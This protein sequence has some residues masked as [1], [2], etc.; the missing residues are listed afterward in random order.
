[1]SFPSDLSP[2]ACPQRPLQLVLVGTSLESESDQVV[3]AGLAVARA[4]RARV[5]LV[6]GAEIQPPLVGFEPGPN[7]A[8][9]RE[10]L[11]AREEKLRQ[12]IERLDIGAAELAGKAVLSGAPH[13]LLTETAGKVGAGLIVVGATGSGPLS[14]E[15]LGSTADRVLRKAAC[16]VLVVRG[17]LRVPPRR[18]LTPVDLSTLSGD[19][20]RCGLHLLAQIATAG[21]TDV[22]AVYALSFLD[23]L[24]RRKQGKISSEELE[25]YSAEELRRFV[26]ENR[27]SDL[28]FEVETA[29]LSG[30]ARFELLDEL[31]EHPVDLVV[32]GTHGRGGLDRLMLGSVASTIA[33]KAPCSV[34]LISPEAALAEAIGEAVTA[35]TTPAW[36]RE[37]APVA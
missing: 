36:H 10:L 28:P 30:E 15:L 22:R 20:F 35:R 3:R 23:T 12:Q 31:K 2:L 13:R 6:H 24:Q 19:A 29:V 9:A 1:M 11:A 16:P 7:L 34:L 33:R 26:L 8:L 14:A 37:P 32:L 4:A 25:R 18:V 21:E 17:E 27:P 5:Y